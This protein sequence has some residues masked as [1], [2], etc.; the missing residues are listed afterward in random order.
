MAKEPHTD[1]QIAT[2]A[3]RD[4]Y[5]NVTDAR[6]SWRDYDLRYVTQRILR[7]YQGGEG[8]MKRIGIAVLLLTGLYAEAQLWACKAATGQ[9]CIGQDPRV[10]DRP[11]K[12]TD[13]GFIVSPRT[14][15][16]FQRLTDPE[17]CDVMNR[18]GYIK[19]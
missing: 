11:C 12:E 15:H 13:I 1:E 7:A 17:I 19:Q 3:M 16:F 4:I 9:Q 18:L 2:D 5:G 8:R 6:T 10:H 14:V